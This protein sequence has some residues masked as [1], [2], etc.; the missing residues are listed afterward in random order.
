M[1]LDFFTQMSLYIVEYPPISHSDIPS[2]P[3]PVP[4]FG[5]AAIT[6]TKG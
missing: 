5:S 4:C 1:A 6:A 3:D 2:Y